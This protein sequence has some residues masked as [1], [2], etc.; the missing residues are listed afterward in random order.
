MCLSSP[1][2]APLP[3]P[4]PPPEPEVLAEVPQGQRAVKPAKKKVKRGLRSVKRSPGAGV[5]TAGSEG[6]TSIA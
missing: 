3:P 4:P 5:S 2:P 1:K 6:G